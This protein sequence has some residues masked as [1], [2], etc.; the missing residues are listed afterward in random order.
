MIKQ[1]YEFNAVQ[2]EIVEGLALRLAIVGY[3]LIAV[4]VVIFWTTFIRTGSLIGLLEGG[5]NLIT[6]LISAYAGQAFRKIVKT[7]DNDIENLMEALKTMNMLYN[8]E[9]FAL[10]VTGI[11]LAYNALR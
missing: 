8:I 1:K 6:G 9:I 10:I 5:L 7:K 2:N 4:G 11:G 3:V